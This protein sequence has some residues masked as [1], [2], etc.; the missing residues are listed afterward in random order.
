MIFYEM[1]CGGCGRIEKSNRNLMS[2]SVNNLASTTESHLNID[3]YL[4]RIYLSVD[5]DYFT[6]IKVKIYLT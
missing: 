4:L 5:G 2:L 6:I 1:G 3:K